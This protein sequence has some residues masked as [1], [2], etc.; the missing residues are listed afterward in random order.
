MG[1]VSFMIWFVEIFRGIIDVWRSS[2]SKENSTE[3]QEANLKFWSVKPSCVFCRKISHYGP[4]NLF[5]TSSNQLLGFHTQNWSGVYSPNKTIKAA[6]SKV[7][8]KKN[9]KTLFSEREISPSSFLGSFK[10][11]WEGVFQTGSRPERFLLVEHSGL[12]MELLWTDWWI[13]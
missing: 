1:N 2:Q 11:G 10:V 9:S 5:P 4:F 6:Q 7:I 3:S 13:I 8:E 12:F